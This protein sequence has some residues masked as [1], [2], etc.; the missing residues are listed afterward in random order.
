MRSGTVFSVAPRSEIAGFEPENAFCS[1]AA[2]DVLP[3]LS[4]SSNTAIRLR[5][6]FNHVRAELRKSTSWFET[7]RNLP[8]FLLGGCPFAQVSYSGVILW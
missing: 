6:A 3:R 2:T 4:E 8:F 1:A 7:R 5:I